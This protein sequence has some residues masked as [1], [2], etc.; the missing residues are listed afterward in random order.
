LPSK[1]TER[2]GVSGWLA[3]NITVDDRITFFSRHG[4]WLDYLAG[5]F[6]WPIIIL[7]FQKLP[8]KEIEAKNVKVR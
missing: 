3:D 5:I 1:V 7:S 6:F 8:K 2:Q 4:Q